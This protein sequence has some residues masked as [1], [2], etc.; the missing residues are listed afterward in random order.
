MVRRGV[1][2]R[3]STLSI[4]C[5]QLAVFKGRIYYRI[6]VYLNLWSLCQTRYIMYIFSRIDFWPNKIRKP[7]NE[8]NINLIRIKKILYLIEY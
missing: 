5:Q 7:P 3:V 1:E 2:W 4:E 8:A 6:V